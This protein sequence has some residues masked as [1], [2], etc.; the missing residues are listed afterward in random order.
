MLATERMKLL[1]DFV[2]L[3]DDTL[4]GTSCRQLRHH[5]FIINSMATTQQ[6]IIWVNL[7]VMM[8]A[9]NNQSGSNGAVDT[10]IAS[11]D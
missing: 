5:Q 11:N 4:E 10:K 2:L 7:W 1:T 9:D 3:S 8:L 6:T